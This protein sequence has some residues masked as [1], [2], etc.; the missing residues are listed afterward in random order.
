M[1]IFLGWRKTILNNIGTDHKCMMITF[2]VIFSHLHEHKKTKI[3]NYLAGNQGRLANN[4]SIQVVA[5]PLALN[6]Q[7]RVSRLRLRV[8]LRQNFIQRK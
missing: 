4:L 6:G 2:N 8:R 5:Q 3:V 1:E 7:Q